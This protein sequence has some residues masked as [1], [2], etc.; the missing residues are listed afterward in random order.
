MGCNPDGNLVGSARA[1]REFRSMCLLGMSSSANLGHSGGRY[2]EILYGLLTHVL[3]TR[4]DALVDKRSTGRFR[5][6]GE[7]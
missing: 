1:G 7:K 5:A 3:G 4:S 2:A 6:E